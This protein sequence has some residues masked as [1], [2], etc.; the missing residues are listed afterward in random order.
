MTQDNNNYSRREFLSKSSAGLA[1]AGFIG[2]AGKGMLFDSPDIQEKTSD[3]KIIYRTLGKTGI[4]IPIVNMGVM[5]TTDPKLL[6]E[7]YKH[8][9]LLFDTALRYLNEE[10]VGNVIKKLGDRKKVYL[11]TKVPVPDY[12]NPGSMTNEEMGKKF[13]IDFDGCMKRLQ[14]DYVD[15]L[16]LHNIK[17]MRDTKN[18]ELLKALKQIKDSGRAR[19]IG[20]ST[21]KLMADVLNEAAASDLFEVVQIA[22]SFAYGNDSKTKKAIK[23]AAGKGKGIIAMKTQAMPR[24]EA[25][26]SA[27]PACHHTAA[28]KYVLNIDGITCA[29]PGYTNTDQ[30]KQDLSVAYGLEYTEEEKKYLED[31]NVAVNLQFC[32]QC[33]KCIPTCPKQVDIP[34]LMRTH[35]YA[36]G[37]SNFYAARSALEEIP[38]KSGLK[39]CVSCTGC[40]AK[41][42]NSVNIYSS[43]NELKAIYT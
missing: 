21:H 24:R 40:I 9:V 32:Q 43:I 16:F 25:D 4:K 37:Y 22:I 41:C 36:G 2:T 38:E 1:S 34:T 14:T 13:L 15:V 19:F 35:M 23:N 27:L 6:M 29:I 20:V 31:K 33:D 39:N 5:N 17:F 8:G 26:K 42:A 3:K 12:N 10:M 11:E 28:L 30:M 18:P 7:S